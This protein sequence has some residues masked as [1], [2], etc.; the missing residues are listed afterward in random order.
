MAR[1]GTRLAVES[2][3]RELNT[4]Y[5]LDEFDTSNAEIVEILLSHE[6]VEQDMG[7]KRPIRVSCQRARLTD[8]SKC[9]RSR[10]L[11]ATARLA[12]RAPVG[13]ARIG[14]SLFHALASRSENQCTLELMFTSG[15][16]RWQ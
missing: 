9:V 11:G 1:L 5:E 16:H 7:R 4:L 10:G 2:L 14:E 8:W 15:T 12:R 13:K 6:S 3:F